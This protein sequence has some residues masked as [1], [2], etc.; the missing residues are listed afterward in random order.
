MEGAQVVR[1]VGNLTYKAQIL[2][3]AI[4]A[5]R[6]DGYALVLIRYQWEQNRRE[7]VASHY[8]ALDATGPRWMQYDAKK[9]EPI[10]HSRVF[11][12]DWPAAAYEI[13]KHVQEAEARAALEA[14]IRETERRE[15]ASKG[16]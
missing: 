8:W 11:S 16:T 9:F 1:D 14:A 13:A 2:P 4:T 6:F 15:A 5:G 12:L 3:G 10:G 7:L